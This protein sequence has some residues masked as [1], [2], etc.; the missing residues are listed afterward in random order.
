MML[1]INPCV[2]MTDRLSV[3]PRWIQRWSEVKRR[4]QVL[5]SKTKQQL[6]VPDEPLQWTPCSLFIM[7]SYLFS[8]K[9]VQTLASTIKPIVGLSLVCV[10][11]VKPTS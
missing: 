11:G 1:T 8:V 4:A 3:P 5:Q 7:F 6:T 10:T 2:N 9:L